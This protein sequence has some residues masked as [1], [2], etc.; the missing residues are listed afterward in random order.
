MIIGLLSILGVYGLAIALVHLAW[1]RFRRG[2]S[3]PIH[4]V[5]ITKN[6]AL[7]IEWYLRTL[8]F[9][10]RL[11]AREVHIVVLDE[12]SE[13][14]TIAIARRLAALRPDHFEI[15]EWYE[16]EQ[17]DRFMAQYESEEVVLVRLSNTKELQNI[18][19]FQ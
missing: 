7:H 6:N 5:L 4:Y 9:V 12:C 11:K 1:T 14:D 19:L 8:L 13:D 2:R 16:A 17:L 15:A 3:K 18:P 10:S